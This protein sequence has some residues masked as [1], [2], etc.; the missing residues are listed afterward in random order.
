MRVFDYL[1][2]RKFL[3][4]WFEE[5]KRENP[6]Y[7]FRLLA[8]QAG[9]KSKSFIAHVMEGKANLSE[10]SLFS[11]GKALKLGPKEFSYLASLVRFNQAKDQRQRELYFRELAEKNGGVRARTVLE[12]EYE[13]YSKWYHNTIRE[14]VTMVDF[15]DD[16]AKLGKLVVPPI[17]A[18]KAR[19]SVELLLKLELIA[20]RNGR[21]VQTEK[22][23]QSGDDITS[24]AVT[25]FHHQN[26]AIAEDA[27]NRFPVG[28]REVS[29]V[30][31]GMSEECFK[32]VKAEVQ[33]FRKKIVAMISSDPKTAER[34]YHVNFQIFPTAVSDGKK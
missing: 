13:F 12:H 19:R 32:K 34:V 33:Q 10:N 3:K 4:D 27:L 25:A 31:G 6:R 17:S 23:L 30:V 29:C 26:L 24:I 15:G 11:L 8:D 20:K 7:S 9:F 5:K 14:L 28:E 16:Y 22:V 2:Y 1:N 18:V 21:Y